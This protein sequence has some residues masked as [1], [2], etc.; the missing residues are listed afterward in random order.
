MGLR[1]VFLGIVTLDVILMTI[2]EDKHNQ[3]GIRISTGMINVLDVSD[4]IPMTM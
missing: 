4:G 2:Y 3:T 1:T